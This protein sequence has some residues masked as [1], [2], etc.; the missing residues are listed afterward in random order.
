MAADLTRIHEGSVDP[1]SCRCHACLVLTAVHCHLQSD[2][3]EALRLMRMS[4]Q[5]LY[6]DKEK[7]RGRLD[8]AQEVYTVLRERQMHHGTMAFSWED[9]MSL[10]PRL[11]V[12]AL[13]QTQPLHCMAGCLR[14]LH[15]PRHDH[16]W[17]PLL[18]N[19][20]SQMQSPEVSFIQDTVR[21]AW[22]ACV[23]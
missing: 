14:C 10:F 18:L 2:I 1:A 9:L 3:D 6:Q 13:N 22:S 7:E 12:C 15:Y 5:S 21:T 16:M 23:T 20:A 11:S 8:P 4:K 17:S 19:N